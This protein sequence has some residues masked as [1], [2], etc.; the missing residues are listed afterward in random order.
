MRSTRKWWLTAATALATTGFALSAPGSAFAADV[1]VCPSGCTW[2]S[3]QAGIDHANAGDTVLVGA[4]TYAENVLVNKA[5]LTVLGASPATTSIVAPDPGGNATVRISAANVTLAG[6]TL[7]RQG[8]GQWDTNPALAGVAIQSVG[9]ATV[10]GNVIEGNRTGIDVNNSSDNTITANRITDNRTGLIFRNVTDNQTVTNNWI[11]DNWTVGVLFLDMS[12][13]TNSPEQHALNSHFNNND[14]SGNWYAQIVDRQA[15]PG[16]PE[17][18]TTNVKDFSG[19]WLG[20]RS[21]VYTTADSAEP[22]YSALIPPEFGGDATP[23]AD[24][25]DIAGPAAANFD[26]TP[27]LGSGDSSSAIAF[28][29]DLSSLVVPSYGAQIGGGSRIQDAVDTATAGGTVSVLAGAYDLTSSVQINKALTLEGPNA[30]ISPNVPGST[31]ANPARVPEATLAVTGNTSAVRIGAPDVTVDGLRFTATGASSGD[32]QSPVIGAGVN[33]GGDAAGATVVDNVFD[34]IQRTAVYF[35]GPTAM[36]GGNVD[37][38]RVTDPTRPATGCDGAVA[39]SICGRQLFNL[40][41]TDN[42]SFSDNVVLAD[43]GNGDRV[44]V[45]NVNNAHGVTIDANVIRNSCTYSCL[46]IAQNTD[47]VQITDNDVSID[48]GNAVQLHE[49]FTGGS[50][51]VTGNTLND[52]A[53]FSVVVDGPSA[54]LSQVSVTRNVLTGGAIRNAAATPL[55]ATCNYYGQFTGPQSAQINGLATTTP[56]LVTADL[57]GPC[58]FVPPVVPPTTPSEPSTNPSTPPTPTST[59][60]QS[61]P[62]TDSGPTSEPRP[63]TEQVQQSRSEARNE[64][65]APVKQ[66]RAFD[67]GGEALVYVPRRGGGDRSDD[68][69]VVSGRTATFNR[70]SLQDGQPQNLLAIGCPAVDCTATV[71]LTFTYKDAEGRTRTVKVKASKQ[72]IEAGAVSLVTLDLP[73]SVRRQILKGNNVRLKITVGM[74]ADGRDLGTSSRTLTL[75]TQKPKK[76]HKRRGRH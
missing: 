13:G 28:M 14:I 43:P 19:N 65:G 45:L 46:T 37:D 56:Y 55:A 64:L 47:A 69:P 32:V 73:K 30:G 7:T 24:A 18:G 68:T 58:P 5:N 10:T 36:D 72:D 15:G 8:S 2:D 62:S 35:N 20:S 27:L 54:D 53:D 3:I 34:Q 60:S 40:W 50:V 74:E 1:D 57:N 67:F 23:P 29:G 38:N 48:V 25:P 12:S 41:Q 39:P 52:P 76:H 9:G 26:V 49:L 31:A 63:T 4:G 22:G 42:L 70:S 75:K 17:P 16:L 6:F 59:Q 71:E 44:R 66:D 21:P 61:S 11:T 33:F 51:T